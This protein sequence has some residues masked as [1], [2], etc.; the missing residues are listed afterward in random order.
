MS[1]LVI[2]IRNNTPVLIEPW[3]SE[4][5]M[6]HVQFSRLWLASLLMMEYWSLPRPSTTFSFYK[7]GA[8]HCPYPFD[9]ARKREIDLCRMTRVTGKK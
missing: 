9:N 5:L 2:S 8:K 1:L 4:P 7:S 3:L 6:N